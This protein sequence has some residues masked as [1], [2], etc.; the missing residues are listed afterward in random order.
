[1]NSANRLM[2][3]RLKYWIMGGDDRSNI[4]AHV[5]G[6]DIAH[7]GSETGF[8]P[9]PPAPRQAITWTL[10]GSD[11]WVAV[12]PTG[13]RWTVQGVPDGRY[14]ITLGTWSR[15]DWWAA[16]SAQAMALVETFE[17]RHDDPMVAILGRSWTEVADAYAGYRDEA[18]AAVHEWAWG[19]WDAGWERLEPFWNEQWG[20]RP[21]TRR[22]S[23]EPESRSSARWYGFDVAHQVVVSREFGDGFG[24]DDVVRRETL[25]VN[26]PD[27]AVVLVYATDGARG[28]YRHRLGEL[29]VPRRDADGRLVRLDIWFQIPDAAG[30]GWWGTAYEYETGRVAT[31]RS[32]SRKTPFTGW[33]HKRTGE[34]LAELRVTH[35]TPLHLRYSE[36]GQLLTI[37]TGDGGDADSVV[38]RRAA[39][40][41]TA[42]AARLV[43]GELPE[44]I[45]A[46]V[47]RVAP[48]DEVYCLGISYPEAA[49]R[50][51]PPSL[52]LGTMPEL[53]RWK[54][55]RS[56]D[57]LKLT[58][59][60]P[61][62]FACFDPEPAELMDAAALLD[63]YQLLNQ[64]WASVNDDRQPRQLLVA[65][66]K[67]LAERDW[68]RLSIGPHGF[69]VY[70]VD[71]ELADLERNLKR[72]VPGAVRRAL[73]AR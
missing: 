14:A 55:D 71:L 32:S 37:A 9:A 48:A 31:V 60:N 67:L 35:R 73:I 65:V 16:S 59:F 42:R 36:N 4:L 2:W 17:A 3:W 8:W 54:E 24:N 7:A 6:E 27:G 53:R 15:P 40:G 12:G 18:E 50:P 39:A 19:P 46:W 5:T 70:A 63:A 23:R 41:A 58:A 11:A 26:T 62:E 51:L 30:F 64:H 10:A 13:T 28:V 20:E 52:G 21:K 68:S 57:P 38:Y 69:A 22:L 61:A 49:A 72:S 47:D 66:A 34:Q 33:E 45:A 44:R 1:M 29:H 56:A 25:R 43:R